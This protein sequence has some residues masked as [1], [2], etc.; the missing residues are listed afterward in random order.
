VLSCGVISAAAPGVA[1]GDALEGFPGAAEGAVLGDGVD[2]VLAAGGLEAAVA[3][4]EWAEGGAVEQY[5]V[6]EEP[7]HGL[8]VR[9]ESTRVRL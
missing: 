7:S 1:A 9:R 6:D 4:H 8:M 3:A 2:G 5:E